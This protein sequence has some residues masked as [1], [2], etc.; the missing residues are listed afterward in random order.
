[1]RNGV[2]IIGL[3]ILLC[4]P[5][6]VWNLLDN[7]SN[8]IEALKTRSPHLTEEQVDTIATIE[9]WNRPVVIRFFY[10]VSKATRGDFGVDGIP[11]NKVLPLILILIASLLSGI[12]ALFALKKPIVSM[13]IFIAA[14]GMVLIAA[15]MGMASYI[16]VGI[17]LVLA[18][19]SYFG[20][21][22]LQKGE[23]ELQPADNN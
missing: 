8:S 5:F 18:I 14:F 2:L 19:L 11:K 20:N 7:A 16:F 23:P 15:I 3:I 10:W 9:G 22:E 21:R 1:M 4:T 6:N 12:G 17:L 13:F